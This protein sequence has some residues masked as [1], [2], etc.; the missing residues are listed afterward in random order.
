MIS[1]G[2]SPASEPGCDFLRA[3]G[4]R[5][6]AER[7]RVVGVGEV[8]GVGPAALFYVPPLVALSLSGGVRH[9]L[10]PVE[11]DAVVQWTPGF[12]RASR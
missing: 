10:L 8:S 4:S 2:R 1:T 5:F 3:L 6:G 11:E 7:R 9:E 12:S